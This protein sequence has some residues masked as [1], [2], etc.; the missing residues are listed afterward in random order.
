MS[1]TVEPISK[2]SDQEIYHIASTF[3]RWITSPFAEL[4]SIAEYLRSDGIPVLLNNKI[5]C[6]YRDTLFAHAVVILNLVPA[7][8]SRILV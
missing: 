1:T 3:Q 7:L 5:E 6:S 4:S 2:F 8:D